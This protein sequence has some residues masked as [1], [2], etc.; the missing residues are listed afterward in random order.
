MATRRWSR[1][2]S[3]FTTGDICGIWVC[4]GEMAAFIGALGAAGDD[5]RVGIALGGVPAM[6]IAFRAPGVS[7][8]TLFET[9]IKA[10]K[11]KTTDP[12]SV[13]GKTVTFA[14]YS[15]FPSPTSS[16]YLYVWGDVLY[17]V[18][19]Q[20]TIGWPESLPPPTPPE[21]T[22]VVEAIP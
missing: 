3:D 10:L 17:S 16:E 7:G 14:F 19:F 2:A 5:L 11:P 8:Q 9:W 1:P 12:V 20:P 22:A 4:P 18:R 15:V 13:A 6:V 21:V